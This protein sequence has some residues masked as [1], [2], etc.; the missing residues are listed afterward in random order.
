MWLLPIHV[1]LPLYVM[2]LKQAHPE[3]SQPLGPQ[4]RSCLADMACGRSEGAHET[5]LRRSDS[6]HETVC[7]HSSDSLH[8]VL[9]APSP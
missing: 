7:T 6:A 9:Q 4:K 8:I 1:V 2:L 3:H 5:V